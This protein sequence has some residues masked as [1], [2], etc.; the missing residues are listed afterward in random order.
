MERL[1]TWPFFYGLLKM[2]EIALTRGIVAIVDDDDFELISKFNWSASNYGYAQA[3]FTKED[4]RYTKISMHRL[5]S[6][7][8]LGDKR[9]VDHINGNTVD[10]RRSN[11]RI[12]SH[13]ENMKNARQR[14][15]NTSGYKG[16]SWSSSLNRWMAFISV[17]GRTKNL[18][19][20][21]D[22]ESA[23]KAYCNA[24]LKYH[25]EFANLGNGC[26]ILGDKND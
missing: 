25:G 15:T 17:E 21:S 11:L 8:R 16:V 23:Y 10:N 4:G 12:V 26:V 14:K 19:M 1:R 20:F 3:H 9:E 6:G 13:S 24:A 5:I 22:K 7:L 2:K 18:G